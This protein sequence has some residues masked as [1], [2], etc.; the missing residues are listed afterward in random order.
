MPIQRKAIALLSGGLD[1]LLAAKVI[2]AQGVHVEA[3]N[4]FTGFCVEGHTQAVRKS[5][6]TKV[7]RH[8]ALASAQQLGIPL[9]VIDISEEYKQVVLNP[10]YGYGTHLNPCIDCK[11]FMVN[12]TNLMV[13]RARELA[14]DKGFDFIVSGEVIG[15]RPKSQRRATLPLIARASDAGDRLLR[16]LCAKHLA[17]TLPER[18]GWVN[19]DKLFAFH[20]RNRTP[21]L[22]L[23]QHFGLS[24]FAQPAGGCCFLT[25]K[26]YAAKLKDLWDSR[27]ERDYSLDDIVLLK[28]GRHIR[29]RPHFKLIIGREEGENKYLEGY[30]RQYAH[31]HIISHNGPLTL[32]DG[33]LKTPDDARLAAAIAAR[34]SQGKGERQV[35]VQIAMPATASSTSQRISHVQ[36]V[37][38]LAPNDLQS[39]W[40]V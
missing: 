30:R 4:F 19:R 18:E 6:P 8:S 33:T 12:R 16:P 20:G 11:I 38:P 5:S 36:F 28:V 23:A 1:S 39:D 31:L 25:D 26:Y 13:N 10:A 27:D 21:Q 22:A 14:S 3:V 2:Q 17:P 34:F 37:R 40:Y 29:P 7:T 35:G 9:H 32:I 15:Q 24:D